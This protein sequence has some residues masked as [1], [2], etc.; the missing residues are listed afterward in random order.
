MRYILL[1]GGSVLATA[2]VITST[3]AEHFCF[4]VRNGAVPVRLV[5]FCRLV[6]G[7]Q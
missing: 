6:A 7:H 5:L 1:V 3:G 2:G 4:N